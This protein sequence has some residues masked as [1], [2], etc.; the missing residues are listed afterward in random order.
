MLVAPAG[1]SPEG[2]WRSDRCEAGVLAL[3][4]VNRRRLILP[5]TDGHAYHAHEAAE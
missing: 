1:H 2:Y 5:G 3:F 4:R